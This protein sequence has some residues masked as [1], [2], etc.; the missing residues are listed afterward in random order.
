MKERFVADDLLAE[1]ARRDPERCVDKASLRVALQ[2]L[3]RE[4]VIEVWSLGHAHRPTV[5]Q[6]A[7]SEYVALRPFL[8]I[9]ESIDE[10]IALLKGKSE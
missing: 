2:R 6:S 1:I 3:A 7:D 10:Q 9:L 5:Y 4:G 8:E